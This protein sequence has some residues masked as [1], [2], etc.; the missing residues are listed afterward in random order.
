MEW[1][2]VIFENVSDRAKF[3]AIFISS[4]VAISVVILNNYFSRKTASRT[5]DIEKLELMYRELLNF[6]TKSKAFIKK[7]YTKEE[8]TEEL[9]ELMKSAVNSLEPLEVIATLHFPD[10]KFDSEKSR[11]ISSICITTSFQLVTRAGTTGTKSKEIAI[12]ISAMFLNQFL[13]NALNR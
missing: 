2:F 1:F 9:R 12:N 8:Q 6:R 11:K 4:V 13:L 10:I 7:L 5:L 3:F